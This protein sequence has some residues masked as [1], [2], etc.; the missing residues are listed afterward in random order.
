MMIKMK[1]ELATKWVDKDPIQ[2]KREL[3]EILD[4]SRTALKQV[5]E[6]VSDMKFI[7]LASELEHSARIRQEL[8]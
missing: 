3:G 5:R 7:S 1:S 2:A 6:L 4:T 8:R